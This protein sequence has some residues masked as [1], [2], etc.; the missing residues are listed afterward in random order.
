MVYSTSGMSR[1]SVCARNSVLVGA[2]LM[3]HFGRIFGVLEVLGW[4]GWLVYGV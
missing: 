3:V 2:L 1:M 4:L